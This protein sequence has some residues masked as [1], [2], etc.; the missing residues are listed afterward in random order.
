MV[1]VRG[2]CHLMCAEERDVLY[3]I[4]D[5]YALLIPHHIASILM[6]HTSE[7]PHYLPTTPHHQRPQIP[8]VSASLGI[9]EVPRGMRFG[10]WG[11]WGVW[12]VSAG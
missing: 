1:F 4:T 8:A 12:D 2:N 7:F 3:C 10:G 6:D 11:G 9:L 5:N